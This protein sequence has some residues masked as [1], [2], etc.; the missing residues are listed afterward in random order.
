MNFTEASSGANVET[1]VRAEDQNR[2]NEFSRNNA[3]MAE[4]EEEYS[5]AKTKLESYQDAE[6]AVEE[7]SCDY[8]PGDIKLLVGESFVDVGED[9]AEKHVE[10]KKK[11]LKGV[12]K[13]YKDELGALR[14]RQGELKK[15]L[16]GRFGNAINLEA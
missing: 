7:I 16:Y 10:E 15:A 13:R 14:K 6:D 11:E 5:R 2:I 9:F 4:I 3:R 8:N 1:Q 12:V